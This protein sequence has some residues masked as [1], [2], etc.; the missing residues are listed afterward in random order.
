M[1]PES[2]YSAHSKSFEGRISMELE[3]KVAL[4][5]G[6][7]DAGRTIVIDGVVPGAMR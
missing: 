1:P 2:S 4:I 3:G 5:S 7:S 6:G